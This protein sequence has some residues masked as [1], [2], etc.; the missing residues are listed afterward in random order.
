MFICVLL[1]EIHLISTS[2]PQIAKKCTFLTLSDGIE[3]SQCS[4]FL[5]L[6]ERKG[7][8]LQGWLNS[9]SPLCQ[10]VRLLCEELRDL[11]VEE[12]RQCAP[13]DRGTLLE[14]DMSLLS[15][16]IDKAVMNNIPLLRR[17]QIW[18]IHFSVDEQLRLSCFHFLTVV[19]NADNIHILDLCG[20]VFN[21]WVYN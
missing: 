5:W 4:S 12:D 10:C 2:L 3:V 20:H 6:L 13:Q 1:K 17:H 18:L 16:V 15:F 19:N 8:E 14:I 7:T 9:Y 11:T 21:F